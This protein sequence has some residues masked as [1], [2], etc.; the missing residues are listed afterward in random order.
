[1]SPGLVRHPHAVHVHGRIHVG[2]LQLR[3]PVRQVSQIKQLLRL[4]GLHSTEVV[5]TL[6]TQQLWEIYCDVA[7]FDKVDLTHLIL[8]STNDFFFHFSIEPIDL[9]ADLANL[10]C[11]LSSGFVAGT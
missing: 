8:A 4:E 1:M 5:F 11:I 6:L 9:A 2:G 7:K 10:Y 3:S